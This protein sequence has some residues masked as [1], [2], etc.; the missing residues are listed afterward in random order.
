MCFVII[1][2][3]ILPFV[4][5][6]SFFGVKGGNVVYKLC[7]IWARLW[8]AFIFIKHKEI[9]EVSHDISRQYIFVANHWSY[10]DIPALVRT[11]QQPVRV[12]GKHEMVKVPVFGWIYRAAAIVVDRS[13][14]EKRAK[15]V[16]AL[17]AALKHGISIF[18]FPEGTFNETPQP[19][20]DFFDGAFRIAIETQ[21][22]I[23][24]L[25]FIDTIDRMHWRG[26]FELTPG[27]SAVVF[28]KEIEVTGYSIKD[29]HILK[30]QVYEVMEEGIRRYRTFNTE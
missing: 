13:S 11:M 14:P 12:L 29:M 9:Y 26:I 28:M 1:M 5:V 15:S 4:L 7:N 17:K 25:L 21:T 27:A 2:F 20:K 16:R 24:P 22:P 10:M 18:I 6:A 23:K 19:L 30:Q 3:L 8:Y